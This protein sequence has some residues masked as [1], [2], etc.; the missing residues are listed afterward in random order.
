MAYKMFDCLIGIN[1]N[2]LTGFYMMTTLAINEL[3]KRLFCPGKLTYFVFIFSR[4]FLKFQTFWQILPFRHLKKACWTFWLILWQA[5]IRFGWGG[6]RNQDY[7]WCWRFS[8]P[9]QLTPL[10]CE[11]LLC[12]GIPFLSTGHLPST[13]VQCWSVC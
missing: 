13:D 12:L 7:Q 9:N 11:C 10:H 3:L 5:R 4:S 2:Q 1:S 8:A 6:Y